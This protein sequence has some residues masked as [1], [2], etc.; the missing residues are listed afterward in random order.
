MRGGSVGPVPPDVSGSPDYDDDGGQTEAQSGGAQVEYDTKVDIQPSPAFPSDKASRPTPIYSTEP[1]DVG[2]VLGMDIDQGSVASVPIESVHSQSVGK[3]KLY[4]AICILLTSLREHWEQKKSQKPESLDILESAH[5]FEQHIRSEF[6]NLH[7]LFFDK[8][9]QLIQEVKEEA[10]GITGETGTPA[11]WAPD[12]EFQQNIIERKHFIEESVQTFEQH[13]SSE[14]CDL[15]QLFLDKEE[16]LI[17]EVKEEAERA[18]EIPS[19]AVWKPDYF[20]QHFTKECISFVEEMFKEFERCKKEV[21]EA[22]ERG[23]NVSLIAPK[24]LAKL[25]FYESDTMAVKPPVDPE[26]VFMEP[27]MANSAFSLPEEWKSLKYNDIR[28]HLPKDIRIYK[29]QIFVL[30]SKGFTSGKHCWEV[31]VSSLDDWYV[32]IIDAPYNKRGKFFVD[33]RIGYGSSMFRVMYNHNI[34]LMHKD[35]REIGVNKVIK[36]IL[37]YLDYDGGQLSFYNSVDM[38]CIYTLTDVFTKKVYPVFSPG[39]KYQ[40]KYPRR[41]K[42]LW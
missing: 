25:P 30:G 15:H 42:H 7:Q 6:C 28:Q 13:I 2:P 1:T 33:N 29:G 41:R 20:S 3:D 17:Q 31:D 40:V 39:P 26:P 23:D 22:E 27:F 5:N 18:G 12:F 16:Q 9:K 38:S 35:A 11:M 32:G 8:E 21:Q 14:F 24:M 19:T 10:K 37:T 34:L 4:A 36:K